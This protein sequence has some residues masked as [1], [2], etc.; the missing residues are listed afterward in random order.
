MVLG[1]VQRLEEDIVINPPE[2]C[3]AEGWYEAKSA[4]RELEVLK[5]GLCYGLLDF[6]F[7]RCTYIY[8]RE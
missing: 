2:G 4:K 8:P 7:G 6:K 1:R 5:S 3:S